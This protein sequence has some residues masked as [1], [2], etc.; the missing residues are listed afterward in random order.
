M[1][2]ERQHRYEGEFDFRSFLE[3]IMKLFIIKLDR[4]RLIKIN[5]DDSPKIIFSQGKSL[6]SSAGFAH[7]KT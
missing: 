7:K 5:N 4:R 6:L 3:N 1:K 2:I